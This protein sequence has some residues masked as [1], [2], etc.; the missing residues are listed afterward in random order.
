MGKIQIDTERVRETGRRLISEGDRLAEIGHELQRAT[1]GLDTW[2]W[3]GR[4]RSRAEPLLNRVRPESARVKH[5]LEELGYKLI[6]IAN[7]FEQRD[8]DAAGDLGGLIW[9]IF[10]PSPP[11]FHFFPLPVIDPPF[12]IPWP[13]WPWLLPILPLPLPILIIGIGPWPE[14]WH[15]FWERFWNWRNGK[16]WKTNE[17]I[18]AEEQAEKERQRQEDEQREK[19]EEEERKR[20]EEEQHIPPTQTGELLLQIDP[21]GDDSLDYPIERAKWSGNKIV[22]DENGKVVYYKTTIREDIKKYGC[23]LTC[24]TMLL[25]N[26]GKDLLVTDL[27]KANYELKTGRDFD[28]DVKNNELQMDDMYTERGLVES[29]APDLK[30]EAKPPPPD[31]QP[32]EEVIQTSQLPIILHVRST[33]SDGHYI[34]VDGINDDGSFRVRDPLKRTTV[35]NAKIDY[36]G[37]AT[38]SIKT[39][40]KAGSIR[41]IE[42]T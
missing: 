3:D 38:Y 34:V 37:D 29:V 39:D 19:E 2:A 23:L 28:L 26:H 6:R 14:W 11:P 41:Y 25:C 40:I 4:S 16:G 17:E 1:G 32:L 8:S 15:D 27:Y 24:Y 42:N 30:L 20:Q 10:P 31:N 36:S 21:K 9:D 33:T 12:K 35:Q 18:E 5:Q 7:I 22:R 13:G